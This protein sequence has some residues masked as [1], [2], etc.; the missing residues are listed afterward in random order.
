M[1]EGFLHRVI[2]Y[3][4][5]CPSDTTTPGRKTENHKDLYEES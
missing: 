1:S 5:T 4:G 2:T 3:T